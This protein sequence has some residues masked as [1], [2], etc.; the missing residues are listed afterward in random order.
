VKA[1]MYRVTA[2]RDKYLTTC[3][4]YAYTRAIVTR[5]KEKSSWNCKQALEFCTSMSFAKPFLFY[6]GNIQGIFDRITET[7]GNGRD[8]MICNNRFIFDTNVESYTCVI[9]SYSQS[10]LR[11]KQSNQSQ[12]LVYNE[13]YT[14]LTF[15]RLLLLQNCNSTK[16]HSA[17]VSCYKEI[18]DKNCEYYQCF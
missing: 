17:V 11:N 16:L 12:S 1:V 6:S 10:P 4:L 9:K 18:K 3:E 8:S 5:G 15:Y 2:V 14:A 7:D 13:I